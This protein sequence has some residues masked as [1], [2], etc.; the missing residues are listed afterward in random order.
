MKNTQRG[1]CG[2]GAL[3]GV[4]L[5][6]IAACRVLTATVNLGFHI[7]ELKE[8]FAWEI[9]KVVSH[10]KGQHFFPRRS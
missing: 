9:S 5:P 2:L 8:G 6:F 7:S 4:Y 10:S 1:V 3:L